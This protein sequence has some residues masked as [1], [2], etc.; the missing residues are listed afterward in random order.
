MQTVITTPYTQ[1]HQYNL[2]TQTKKPNSQIQI[3]SSTVPLSNTS[4]PLHNCKQI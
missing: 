1:T 3:Y 2:Q 4:N